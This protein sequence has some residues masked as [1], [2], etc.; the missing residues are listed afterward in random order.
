MLKNIWIA[1]QI[2]TE[3]PLIASY[4]SISYDIH[5]LGYSPLRTTQANKKPPDYQ[6]SF[7]FSATNNISN[8]HYWKSRYPDREKT[9]SAYYHLIA[10]FI[11]EYFPYFPRFWW[12]S[13]ITPNPLITTLKW[14][15]VLRK[16]LELS[17]SWFIYWF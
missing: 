10:F 15:L 5:I 13:L 6:G 11:C 2:R 3:H 12:I 16:I 17:S 7:L 4:S 1:T 9:Q 14:D 8:N